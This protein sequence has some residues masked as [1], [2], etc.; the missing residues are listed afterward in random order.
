MN[1]Y[2]VYRL[3]KDEKLKYYISVC[4]I[5]ALLGL[6]FY[7]NLIMSAVAAAAAIPLE[8]VYANYLRNKRIET[9]QEGFRDALYSISGAVSAGKQLPQAI[10]DAAE[11][12]ELSYGLSSDIGTELRHI[13]TVYYETH[14]DVEDLLYDFARRSGLEEIRQFAQSC[15]ICRR[16]GGDMEAVSL[17]TASVLIDRMEVEREVKGLIAQKKTDILLLVAMPLAVLLFLNLVSFDYLEPLYAGF[18]G[19]FL[20][21]VCLCG[22]GIALLWSLKITD[23]KL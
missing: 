16:C 8:K 3:S 9:L 6:L 12:A 13:A 4:I 19:R 5:L 22:M 20:M 1:D 2:R 10:S 23:I 15:S 7:R 17:R 11:S 21:T 18:A 14:S